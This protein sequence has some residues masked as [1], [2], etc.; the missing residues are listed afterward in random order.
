MGGPWPRR[1]I[2]NGIHAVVP[3]QRRRPRHIVEKARS[4]Q[5]RLSGDARSIVAIRVIAARIGSVA[6]AAGNAF[7]LDVAGDGLLTVVVDAGAI[8][9]LV[10]NGGL[11]QADGGRVLMTALSA[12]ELLPSAVN[13]GGVIQARTIENRN[14]TIRLLGDMNAGVVNVEGTLDAGAPQGGDGGFIVPPPRR[15]GDD[16]RRRH[17]AA[18]S[19]PPANAHRSADF[20]KASRGDI[21]VAMLGAARPGERGNERAGAAA[22]RRR[23]CERCRAVC[24]PLR[25]MPRNSN[26]H[27][28]VRQRYP[29]LAMESGR[30]VA[31]AMRRRTCG[32]GEPAA[33]TIRMSSLD[34]GSPTTRHHNRT[35]LQ[36][37]CNLTASALAAIRCT[38]LQG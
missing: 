15:Y 19:E 31:A 8:D 27:D 24:D 3:F 5:A 33:A 36:A 18:P 14:G 22:W 21:T 20:T 10:R 11:I 13:N 35:A 37:S 26:Q 1:D 4:T 2:G 7:T 6:L 28:D 9:A 23:S 17:A 25:S 38:A 12:G 30:R 16:R 32:P 29:S 34:G